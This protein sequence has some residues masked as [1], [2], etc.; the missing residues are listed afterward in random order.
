MIFYI[1]VAL[2]ISRASALCCPGE[3]CNVYFLAY[4]PF[5]PDF[6]YTNYLHVINNTGNGYNNA[7]GEL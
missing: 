5:D 4:G 1:C 6:T 7:N 2:M 3:P